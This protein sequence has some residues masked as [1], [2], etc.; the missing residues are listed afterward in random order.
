MGRG[1]GQLA[2]LKKTGSAR[3]AVNIHKNVIGLCKVAYHSYGLF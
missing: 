1:E 3:R 2:I